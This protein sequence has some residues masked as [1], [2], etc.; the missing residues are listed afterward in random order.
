MSPPIKLVAAFK[1]V[2]GFILRSSD[3]GQHR[4]SSV[5]TSTHTLHNLLALRESRCPEMDSDF[6]AEKSRT[7]ELCTRDSDTFKSSPFRPA[8][9]RFIAPF[10][11]RALCRLFFSIRILC[12]MLILSIHLTSPISCSKNPSAFSPSS[13]V[14]VA[15]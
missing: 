2:T 1:K 7:E 3:R 9:L 6:P 11:D 4:Q 13:A 8:E 10:N 15:N 12:I 14:I 5:L